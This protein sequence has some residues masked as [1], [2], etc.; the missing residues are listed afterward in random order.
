MVYIP[1]GEFIMGSEEVDSESLAEEAG[2]RQKRYYENEKPQRKVSV[3]AFHLDMYEVTNK[4]YKVFVDV[5]SRVPPQTWEG[6]TYAEGRDDHPV[7]FVTWHDADTYCKWANKRLPME[8]EWEKAARGPNGNIYPWGNEYDEEKA[9]LSKGDTMS[10][11]SYET[12]KSH[13]GVY[14]MGGN[15]MEWIDAWYEPYPGNK[16]ENKD[17]G[18]K[19]RILRGGSGSVIGHWVMS[20]IFARPSFRH[21]YYPLGADVDAGFRCAKDAE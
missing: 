7:N 16:T 8:E 6:R 2:A 10:V 1:A 19:Y 12:D 18:K 15:V 20:K 11:G 14:D 4:E 21:Y 3:K 13:Y 9:N 17:Y 5:T